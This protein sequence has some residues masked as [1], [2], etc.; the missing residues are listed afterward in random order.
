MEIA[1]TPEERIAGII[2]SQREYFLSGETL[3][4][5]FRKNMLKKFAAAMKNGKSLCVTRFGQ[6]CT[7]HMKRHTSPSLA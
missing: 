5:P 7:N 4:L 2:Q 6:T 1:N 3:G